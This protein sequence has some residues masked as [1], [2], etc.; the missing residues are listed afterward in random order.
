M[1]RREIK[2]KLD[3]KVFDKNHYDIFLLLRSN[4]FTQNEDNLIEKKLRLKK[5]YNILNLCC[6]IIKDRFIYINHFDIMGNSFQIDYIVFIIMR[7][8]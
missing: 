7:K 5:D 4:E 6:N 3:T 8:K 1:R 2:N